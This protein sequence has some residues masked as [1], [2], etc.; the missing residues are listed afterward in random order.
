[1]GREHHRSSWWA[2]WRG[3]LLTVPQSDAA[4]ILHHFPIQR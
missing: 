1:V 4:G 2:S 3:K